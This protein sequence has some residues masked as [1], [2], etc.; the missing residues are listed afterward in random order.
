MVRKRWKYRC[1]EQ[2]AASVQESFAPLL[3]RCSQ[4]L[5]HA[6]AHAALSALLRDASALAEQLGE[7]PRRV[8]PCFPPHYRVVAFLCGEHRRHTGSMVRLVGLCAPQ[9][10]N[11]DVLAALAW[12]Q[13]YRGRVEALGAGPDGGAFDGAPLGRRP[14]NVY[15]VAA[16]FCPSAPPAGIRP[17]QAAGPLRFTACPFR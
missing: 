15:D 2:I 1:F 7:A 12:V 8:A 14:P 16:W 4:L 13:D 9:L 5:A 3:Q 17:P 10:S 11:A 6:D